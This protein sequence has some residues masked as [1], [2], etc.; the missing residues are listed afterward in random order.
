MKT[1]NIRNRS[2]F[3]LIELLVVISI[4]GILAS[5]LLPALGRAK[6][7][8]QGAVCI[9]NLK[10]L[11]LALGMFV[12]EHDRIYPN[13]NEVYYYYR[14]MIQPYGGLTLH[15]FACPLDSF[16][17]D[18]LH[19]NAEIIESPHLLPNYNFVSYAFNGRRP[20][21]IGY[22]KLGLAGKPANEIRAPAR[23][24]T[25][26]ELSATFPISWHQGNR[27][28]RNNAASYLAFADGHVSLTKIYWNGGVSKF[29]FP[30]NSDPISGFDYLWSP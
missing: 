27:Q 26:Y 30:V 5:L 1:R 25:L 7:R 19:D 24:V 22:P 29:D 11:D 9:N 14:Q 12:E 17:I 23:T 13:T 6:R 18:P 3:T 20:T 15:S 16:M 2:G 4:I 21:M 8:A 10:Q 28:R